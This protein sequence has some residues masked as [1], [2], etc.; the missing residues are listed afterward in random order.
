MPR[1]CAISS[2]GPGNIFSLHYCPVCIPLST[3]LPVEHVYMTSMIA[4]VLVYEVCG[5]MRR[6]GFRFSSRMRISRV[7]DRTPVT[8]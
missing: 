8:V 3:A 6:I 5:E 2:F 4:I 7:V 1:V